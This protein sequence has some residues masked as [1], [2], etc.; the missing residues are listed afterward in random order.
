MSALP[1]P[2]LQW[3][4]VFIGILS[5][6]VYSAYRGV[7]IAQKE[8]ES[9]MEMATRDNDFYP[10]ELDEMDEDTMDKDELGDLI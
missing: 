10:L 3:T 2:N 9:F 5:F 1:N 6:L 4:G 8:T 7:Q